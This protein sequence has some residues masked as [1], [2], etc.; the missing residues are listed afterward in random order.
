MTPLLDE[1]Y[2]VLMGFGIRRIY[3]DFG[4]LSVLGI[5]DGL[6]IRGVIDA[7]SRV[8]MWAGAVG[9]GWLSYVCYRY[10]TSEGGAE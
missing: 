5:S 7:P 6:A 9:V 2:A 10:V 8:E 1:F 3:I 4:L